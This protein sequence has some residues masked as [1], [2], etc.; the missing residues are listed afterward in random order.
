MI[1]EKYCRQ[2]RYILTGF[3]SIT[4]EPVQFHFPRSI[5]LKIMEAKNKLQIKRPSL[6]R[7]IVQYFRKLF[8][9]SVR[10][11]CITIEILANGKTYSVNIL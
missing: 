5:I 10:A 6:F 7:K 3:D 1:N 8:G 11:K 2:Q 9:L 4:R